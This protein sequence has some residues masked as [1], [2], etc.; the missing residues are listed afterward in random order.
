MKIPIKTPEEI[1]KL[2]ASAKLLSKTFKEVESELRAGLTTQYIDEIVEGFI[3]T[4]G[5]IPAFKGYNGFPASACISVDCEVVHGIPDE[6]RIEDGQIVS[7]DIG[8]NLDGYFSDACKTYPI[9][10]ISEEKKLLLKS[11]RTALHRGIKKCRSGNRLSDISHAIQT[12]V[13]SKGYSV[14]RDLVGHGI[15]K[16]LHEPPQIPNFGA[17]R[18]GPKLV[19]G[20]VFAIEPMVNIGV[21]SIEIMSDGWTIKTAD[22]KP[23]GHFEHTVLITEGKPEILT[24]GLDDT[25]I[26]DSNG[27]RSAN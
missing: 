15:G 16:E 5:A 17:P 10:E 22:R 26:G 4:A 7:I 25:S 20:M 21:P 24:S 23:S 3:T 9:G 18:K 2:R 27:E 14:V 8:V 6:R 12:Y 19:P 11:T 1:E 13:E